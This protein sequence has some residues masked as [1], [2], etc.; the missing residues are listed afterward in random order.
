MYDFLQSRSRPGGVAKIEIRILAAVARIFFGAPRLAWGCE[1]F[2]LQ[3]VPSGDAG[4]P[5]MGP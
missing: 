4:G 5:R 2:R 1:F 3:E